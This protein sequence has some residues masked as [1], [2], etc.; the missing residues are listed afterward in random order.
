MNK[1]YLTVRVYF[2]MH[3]VLAVVRCVEGFNSARR[4]AASGYTE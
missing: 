1:W 3:L 2:R 4:Q